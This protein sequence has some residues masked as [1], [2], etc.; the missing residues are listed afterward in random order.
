MFQN[1]YRSHAAG[2][3]NLACALADADGKGRGETVVAANEQTSMRCGER[4]GLSPSS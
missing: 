1:T 4:L 3:S 2:E